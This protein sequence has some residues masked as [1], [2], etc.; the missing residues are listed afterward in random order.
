MK[1]ILLISMF[2]LPLCLSY[3]NISQ[4]NITPSNPQNNDTITLQSIVI[5]GDGAHLFDTVITIVGNNIFINACYWYGWG[6]TG[7][8]WRDTFIYKL[9]PLPDGDYN[10]KYVAR[11][12][13]DSTDTFCLNYNK[14]DSVARTFTV[15][16]SSII[17]INENPFSFSPNPATTILTI[18]TNATTTK[19]TA[20]IFTI[21][22]KAATPKIPLVITNTVIDVAALPKGLYFVTLQSNTGNAVKKFVKE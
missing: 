21:E 22:G 15:G 9:G 10:I 19:T 2:L 8:F 11:G 18:A 20:Q 7:S 17:S 16:P 14:I 12:T 5:Y 4:L 3:S 6:V 13:V 1:K